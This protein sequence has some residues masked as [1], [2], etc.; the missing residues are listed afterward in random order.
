MRPALG[1]HV[2][3]L[4]SV[5]TRSSAPPGWRRLSSHLRAVLCV[6]VDTRGQSQP[7]LR[8]GGNC[9]DGA[10]SERRTPQEYLCFTFL[11]HGQSLTQD[12]VFVHMPYNNFRGET[13]VLETSPLQTPPQKYK[14]KT[15]LVRRD[16]HLAPKSPYFIP[17]S[18]LCHRNNLVSRAWGKVNA[19]CHLAAI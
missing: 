9:T 19:V 5:R 4:R 2:R 13:A 15:R 3:E 10:F 17:S 8:C 12:T 14:N 1:L 18:S 7:L 11:I 16:A 6:S